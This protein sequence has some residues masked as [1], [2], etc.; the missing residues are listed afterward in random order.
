MFGRG[1]LRK[2][3][4]KKRY[5]KER[6]E[7][8]WTVKESEVLF[9]LQQEKALLSFRYSYPSRLTYTLID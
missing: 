6:E 3:K 8:K 7:K 2:W 4:K 1:G 9:D 5:D